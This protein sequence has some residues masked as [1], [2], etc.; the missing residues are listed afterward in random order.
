MKSNKCEKLSCDYSHNLNTRITFDNTDHFNLLCNNCLSIL[1]VIEIKS[2]VIRDYKGKNKDYCS[3]I[4]CV[5]HKC[6][7]LGKRKIYWN[8]NGLSENI[9]VGH[10]DWK[11]RCLNK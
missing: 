5:C 10:V 2:I 4:Y 6:K 8:I 7:S 9:N 3:Y 11:E 1:E